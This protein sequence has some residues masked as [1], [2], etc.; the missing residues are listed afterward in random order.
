MLIPIEIKS[1]Q[2]INKD[3]FE[4]LKKWKSLAGMDAQ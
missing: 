2:T 3:F 1:G 4:Y